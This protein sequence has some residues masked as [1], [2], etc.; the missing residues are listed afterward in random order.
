M[1]IYLDKYTSSTHPHVP[2][3]SITNYHSHHHTACMVSVICDIVFAITCKPL[4]TFNLIF[5][6]MLFLA[7]LIHN[8]VHTTF[9]L[10]MASTGFDLFI[11]STGFDLFIASTGF[12]LFIVSTGFH[13][14][15]NTRLLEYIFQDR[16]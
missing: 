9:D 11:A 2:L 15:D 6:T 12:D 13:L 3:D 8:L 10:F 16:W 1:D 5:F 7:F 4:V 14:V